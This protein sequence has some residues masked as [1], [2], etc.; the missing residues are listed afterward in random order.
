[1]KVGTCNTSSMF[2]MVFGRDAFCRCA[3]TSLQ[4][5]ALLFDAYQGSIVLKKGLQGGCILYLSLKFEN[6]TDGHLHSF[7]AALCK[8]QQKTRKH[9]MPMTRKVPPGQL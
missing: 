2:F 6:V 9:K 8:E 7:K 5:D 3:Y 4:D 1:M